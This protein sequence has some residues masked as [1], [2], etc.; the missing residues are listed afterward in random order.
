MLSRLRFCQK[1]IA[2]Q[3]SFPELRV[4]EWSQE[5]FAAKKRCSALEQLSGSTW[6]RLSRLS[7][8]IRLH[9][10]SLVVVTFNVQLKNNPRR[11]IHSGLIR[12]NVNECT[13]RLA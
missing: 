4:V 2:V 12:S 1:L 5:R 11:L 13:A 10:P 8:W 9:R 3:S 6:I 7:R